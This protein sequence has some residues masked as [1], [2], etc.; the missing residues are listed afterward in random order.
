MALGTV[1]AVA[2]WVE[3]RVHVC[4]FIECMYLLRRRGSLKTTAATVFTFASI[5]LFVL[6]TIHT[7]MSCTPL[8]FS[9][10]LTFISHIVLNL[11]RFINTFVV[12]DSIEAE[13]YWLDFSHGEILTYY[14][15][16]G[17]QTW[18]GDILIIY[19]CWFIFNKKFISIIIP[20]L[21]VLA[22]IIITAVTYTGAVKD[23]VT[24]IALADT[25]FPLSLAQNLM[26]TGLILYKIMKQH[27]RLSALSIDTST[28]H[29]FSSML[30]VARLII[31]S[32]ALYLLAILLLVIFYFAGACITPTIGI[33][34]T[35]LSLR[36]ATISDS[37]AWGSRST[38]AGVHS[39]STVAN[40]RFRTSDWQTPESWDADPDRVRSGE[41]E[42]QVK[43]AGLEFAPAPS[44]GKGS[45]SRE[46]TLRID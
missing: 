15:L 12:L 21:L 16:T 46:G 9:M 19:R 13:T 42:L 10:T 18:L 41:T 32:A 30:T 7:G 38:P 11:V 36:L 39:R 33:N 4:L 34:F 26:T 28:T 2:T 24:A 25:I 27:Y 35:L 20:A 40:V 29:S 1:R 44:S 22:S 6:S 5:T 8:F 37:D 17:V 14:V 23:P 3:V 31:E 43:N 45:V